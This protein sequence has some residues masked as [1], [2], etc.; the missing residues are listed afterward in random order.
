MELDRFGGCDASFA[1]G[2]HEMRK[3]NCCCTIGKAW[4]DDC[5][6]CPEEESESFIKMCPSGFSTFSLYLDLL[7]NLLL[8]HFGSLSDKKRHFSLTVLVRDLVKSLVLAVGPVIFGADFFHSYCVLDTGSEKKS[9]F[10]YT[11]DITRKRVTSGGAHL[12]G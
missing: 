5:E 7:W 8:Y 10:H 4:G 11:G 9:N 6:I 12:R 1:F 3:A 2:S